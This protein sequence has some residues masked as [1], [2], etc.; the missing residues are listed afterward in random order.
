MNE[1][2]QV[3]TGSQATITARHLLATDIDTPPSQLLYT[4]T[5]PTNG[6]L[7]LRDFMDSSITNF[8]QQQI[9]EGRVLFV[10]TGWC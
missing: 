8:T 5:Q 3:W 6:E 2:L 4:V 1:V 10:H 9:D 7:K